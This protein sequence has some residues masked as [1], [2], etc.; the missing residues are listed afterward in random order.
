MKKAVVISAAADIDI[1]SAWDYLASEK[2]NRQAADR[3]VGKFQAAMERIADFPNQ[4]V[5]CPELSVHVRG[6]RRIRVSSYTIYYRSPNARVV[7]ILRI[8]HSR[9]SRESAMKSWLRHVRM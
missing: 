6:I 4:G 1:A 8:I 3:I 9:R 7:E 2:G 5:A